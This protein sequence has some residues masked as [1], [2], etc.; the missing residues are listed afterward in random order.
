MFPLVVTVLIVL[1]FLVSFPLSQD[2]C[3]WLIIVGICI[4]VT[5]FDVNDGLNLSI[6]LT[7][8]HNVSPRLFFLVITLS[9]L[10]LSAG[11]ALMD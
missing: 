5:K 7:S 4:S 9:D 2:R 10:L 8:D 6:P 11:V 3:H 1:V